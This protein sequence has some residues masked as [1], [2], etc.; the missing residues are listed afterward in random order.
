MTLICITHEYIAQLAGRGLRGGAGNV[1]LMLELVKNKSSFKLFIV[2]SFLT[3]EVRRLSSLSLRFSDPKHL[4][5][6]PIFF[7]NLHDRRTEY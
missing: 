4:S 7:F 2:R 1:D 3:F 6:H 5:Q